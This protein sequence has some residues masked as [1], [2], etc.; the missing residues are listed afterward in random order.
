[1]SQNSKL[2]EALAATLLRF[3]EIDRDT[4]EALCKRAASLEHQV[5]Q[6]TADINR[7]TTLRSML[8]DTK[9]QL[10]DWQKAEQAISSS[11]LKIRGILGANSSAWMEPN[12]AEPQIQRLYEYTENVAEQ[13]VK[14]HNQLQWAL[15]DLLAQTRDLDDMYPGEEGGYQSEALRSAVAVA[16]SLVGEQ[17]TEQYPIA[18]EPLNRRIQELE[19]KLAERLEPKEPIF[20]GRGFSALTSP[21]WLRGVPVVG[22]VCE[23]SKRVR[24]G[25]KLWLKGT[26]K[27]LSPY[28]IVIALAE[29][30]D[31]TREFVAHPR[32]VEFRAL[33]PEF[34][35]VKDELPQADQPIKWSEN[36]LR[37]L[38]ADVVANRET[39]VA[40]AFTA[41]Q[42]HLDDLLAH[43]FKQAQEKLRKLPSDVDVKV[44]VTVTSTD[45][46][47]RQQVQ[48]LVDAQMK[49]GGSI[50][51]AI[52]KIGGR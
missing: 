18:D 52:V 25:E 7:E 45:A 48:D 42:K 28:T 27:Y 51:S 2:S 33:L 36:A 10:A 19:V 43:T 8:Q 13:L 35:A 34:T 1:M 44:I 49:P 30:D 50:H 12:P 16:G 40:T 38:V 26:V 14:S 29:A 11:Y 37:N 4:I 47:L 31:G 22:S 15:R 6:N 17:A 3:K 23:F 39:E 32:T 21:D 20:K 5:T 24:E 46:E 41:T 9:D